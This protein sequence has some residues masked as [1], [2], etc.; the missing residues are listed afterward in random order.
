M[1]APGH[2]AVTQLTA[3]ARKGRTS[4]G[5]DITACVHVADL[6]WANCLRRTRAVIVQPQDNASTDVRAGLNL[7]VNKP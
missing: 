7:I 5:F 2:A 1:S 3:S 6:P 4:A